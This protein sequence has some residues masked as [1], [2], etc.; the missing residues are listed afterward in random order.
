VKNRKQ[1]NPLT[2]T[3]TTGYGANSK[4][5]Y[6]EVQAPQL[7]VQMSPE[8]ARDLAMNLLQAA[9]AAYSDAFLVEFLIDATGASIPEAAALLGEFRAWREQ[10]QNW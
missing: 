2:Y 6:V 8:N 9:E 1:P 4:E 5:P 3:V 10:K 7:R